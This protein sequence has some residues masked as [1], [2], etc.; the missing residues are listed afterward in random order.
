MACLVAIRWEEVLHRQRLRDV[1][2]YALSQWETSLHCND[3]FHWLGT[4][5]YLDRS[6]RPRLCHEGL[7]RHWHETD[8]GITQIIPIMSISWHYSTSSATLKSTKYRLFVNHF[9]QISSKETLP[10]LCQ[11]K[12]PV[13]HGFPHKWRVVTIK[14]PWH[15]AIMCRILYKTVYCVIYKT[16]Q[17]VRPQTGSV[18]DGNCHY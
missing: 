4:Y 7:R 9:V 6:L 2:R 5:M 17:I 10:V 8:P 13:T 12:P 15:N 14:F 1:S 16:W 11:M 18:Y 3:V